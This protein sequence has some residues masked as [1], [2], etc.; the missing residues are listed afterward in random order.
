VKNAKEYEMSRAGNK[1]ERDK[2]HKLNFSSKIWREEMT[3]K[4]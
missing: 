3:L 2:K 4:T 1:H